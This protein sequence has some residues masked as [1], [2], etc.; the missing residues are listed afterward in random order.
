MSK[1]SISRTISHDWNDVC[2]ISIYR[3]LH[4]IVVLFDYNV[5]VKTSSNECIVLTH[6]INEFVFQSKH[7][8]RITLIDYDMAVDVELV[9]GFC[10]WTQVSIDA[11]LVKTEEA[12]DKM[13][14]VLQPSVHIA[15]PDALCPIVPFYMIY[16]TWPD[17]MVSFSFDRNNKNELIVWFSASDGTLTCL[18]TP[19]TLEK[20]TLLQFGSDIEMYLHLFHDSQQIG[21][22]LIHHQRKYTWAY[23]PLSH[24]RHWTQRQ[25][26]TCA[27]YEPKIRHIPESWPETATHMELVHSYIVISSACKLLCSSYSLRDDH[28][29]LQFKDGERIE[30]FK[31]R[32]NDGYI[33]CLTLPK[34][35]KRYKWTTVSNHSVRVQWSGAHK[36]AL[37]PITTHNVY[38]VVPKPT[39]KPNPKPT[40]FDALYQDI[41]QKL[42]NETDSFRFSAWCHVLEDLMALEKQYN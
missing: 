42:I 13:Q 28:C 22:T 19:A 14:N 2:G 32:S 37:L 10:S 5:M 31:H 41:T 38:Q 36:N 21:V 1:G 27:R 20:H 8:L 23:L 3:T 17:E 9:D 35:G 25:N 26:V 12:H 7:L 40:M 34:E 29:I 24:S 18:E 15:I 4:H 16:G 39:S 30:Y 11:Y 33:L 6:E